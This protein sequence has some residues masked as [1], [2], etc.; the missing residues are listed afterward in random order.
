MAE[1]L[2]RDL[3]QAS[4]FCSRQLLPNLIVLIGRSDCQKYC[5]DA[6][7]LAIGQ[8]VGTRVGSQFAVHTGDSEFVP[9]ILIF[10]A[11]ARFPRPLASHLLVD[12]HWRWPAMGMGR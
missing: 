6:N 11:V 12:R 4:T 10:T 9:S 1:L 5:V 7:E 2:F 3:Q 8:P